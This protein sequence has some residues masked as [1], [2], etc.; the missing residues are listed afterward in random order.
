[1][2][3]K[4]G[5]PLSVGKQLPWVPEWMFNLGGEVT[6]RDFTFTLTGRYVSKQYGNAENTDGYTECMVPTIPFSWPIFVPA[7]S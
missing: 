6:Y 5:D 7:T 4:F 2:L 3:S 1:M